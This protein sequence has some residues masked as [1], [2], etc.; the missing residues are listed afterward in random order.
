MWRTPPQP[1][2]VGVPDFCAT[3]APGP[4]HSHDRRD[5]RHPVTPRVTG[6]AMRDRPDRARIHARLLTRIERL[7]SLPL[8]STSSDRHSSSILCGCILAL[9]SPAL[10]FGLHTRPSVA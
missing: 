4:P 3:F 10:L 2:S 6:R 1:A 5:R 8:P 7:T 9:L